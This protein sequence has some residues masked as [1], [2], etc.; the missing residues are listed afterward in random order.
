[1]NAQLQT[2]W[3][4]KSIPAHVDPKA[5]E[6][7]AAKHPAQKRLSDAA[8]AQI[9]LCDDPLPTVRKTKNVSKYQPYFEALRTGE[10]SCVKCPPKATSPIASGLR[11]YLQR[12]GEMGAYSIQTVS[13]YGD[14]RGRVWL[15]ERGEA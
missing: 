10:R 12:R 13:D 14:G 3:R 11:K 5:V 9:E 6:S 8:M 1:M 2:V 4:G 15:V 7:K